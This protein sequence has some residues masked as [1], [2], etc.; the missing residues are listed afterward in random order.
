MKKTI[1][2]CC[3]SRQGGGFHHHYHQQEKEEPF[4][5]ALPTQRW[6]LVFS[7]IIIAKH[8]N[9]SKLALLVWIH[10]HA[11][12]ENGYH[13]CHWQIPRLSFVPLL[14]FSL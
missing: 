5:R 9:S 1:G 11:T 13:P 7:E 6:H 2:H 10:H 4:C 3:I 8:P 14:V 12:G